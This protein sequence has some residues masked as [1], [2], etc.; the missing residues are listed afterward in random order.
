MKKQYVI[1]ACVDSLQ[2]AKA[3]EKNGADQIELCTRLDVGGLTPDFNLIKQV[4]KSINIP[5]RVMVRPREGD[6][7]YTDDEV[8]NMIDSISKCRYLNVEGVVIGATTSSMNKLDME[9]L[10]ELAAVAYPLNVTIH[11]AIDE[12]TSPVKEISR[13]K[14][15]RNIDAVLSSGKANTAQEGITMLKEMIAVGGER[16]NVISAGKITNNNLPDIHK[17]I[18]GRMYH[19]RKIV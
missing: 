17:A 6:F 9:L 4:K 5:V 3:A 16:L 15:V 7:Y 8:E 18:G 13:L 11:K 12:C 14:K 1:E 10:E 19:G 2:A